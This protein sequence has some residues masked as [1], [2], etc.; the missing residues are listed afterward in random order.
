MDPDIDG[1]G[2]LNDDDDSPFGPGGGQDSDIDGDGIPNETDPD[3]DGDGILNDDDDSPFG[4]GGG[5]LA[6][7]NIPT[8]AKEVTYSIKGK[9]TT[10]TIGSSWAGDFQPFAEEISMPIDFK[11]IVPENL[12]PVLGDGAWDCRIVTDR[13]IETASSNISK[14]EAY[15]NRYLSIA[16]AK[17]MMDNRGI[18]VVEK[19][20]PEV[21][22]YYP[23]MPISIVLQANNKYL[24]ASVSSATWAFDS[25]N[26]LCSFDCY[27]MT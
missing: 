25:T 16:M 11:P 12:S 20:R 2:I 7:C 1:D 21:F 23:F 27:V 14:Y 22:D 15:I 8:E 3:I 24:L 4:T 13:F 17:R 5:Q 26:A 9:N 6:S 10:R 19:M 18:R